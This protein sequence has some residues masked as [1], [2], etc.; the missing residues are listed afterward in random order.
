MFVLSSLFYFLIHLLL[1]V[2]QWDVSFFRYQNDYPIDIYIYSILFSFIVHACFLFG[3]NSFQLEGKQQLLFMKLSPNYLK[4]VFLVSILVFAIG[5]YF[6]TKNIIAILSMGFDA[7]ITDRISM[8]V[9]NGLALLLAH[10]T[11]ISCLLFFFIYLHSNNI[12]WLRKAS[13]VSFITAFLLAAT[14]YS[15]NSNR[16]SLFILIISLLAFS[17]AFNHKYSGHITK[18][19]LK[20]TITLILV[21]IGFSFSLHII[22]KVR[23]QGYD[24]IQQ[25]SQYGMVNSLNGAFGNHENIVWLL[26][27]EYKYEMGNTYTAAIA[28]FIPRA[29]WADKPLGAGPKLKNLIYPGSYVVGRRGNSSLTTGFQTELLMNFGII[30]SVVG[31]LVIAIFL[32]LYFIFLRKQ[33]S[34]AIKLIY[35]F[36]VVVFSTQ[37][38]YAEFLGFFARYIFSIIP[39]ILVYLTTKNI[40]RVYL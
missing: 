35:L 40:K 30:G 22:G 34:P 38:F 33:N 26:S 31:S 29:L 23:H 16:N 14:Y 1:P 13:F 24:S 37:F 10:W 27:H 28:N 15:I 20:K 18:S 32:S 19:Q 7:Y 39:F 5:A 6:S 21:I 12:K 17:M 36:S 11:Y 8:G 9:G 25:D 2:L 3:I 4:R